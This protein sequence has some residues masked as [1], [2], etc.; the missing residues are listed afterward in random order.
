MGSKA[1]PSRISPQSNTPLPSEG[2][3]TDMYVLCTQSPR[4]G[5]RGVGWS[6]GCFVQGHA[7]GDLGLSLPPAHSHVGWNI[8][9]RP[10]TLHPTLLACYVGRY[11]GCFTTISNASI[12]TLQNGRPEICRVAVPKQEST[13]LTPK[14]E[15]LN[16]ITHALMQ[17]PYLSP[18]G[19]DGGDT[20]AYPSEDSCMTCISAC[21][22]LCVG[23]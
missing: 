18:E 17:L 5:L 21:V 12:D 1:S 20:A 10:C 22:I 16:N 19:V 4:W 8:W 2:D 7:D 23:V 6:F 14:T 11:F 15:H 9:S 3:N 13:Q